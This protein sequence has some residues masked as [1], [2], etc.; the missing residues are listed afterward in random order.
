[1]KNVLQASWLRFAI[2]GSGLL[3]VNGCN[4]LSDAQLTQILTSF[5][6]TS[7]NAFVTNLIGA[8]IDSGTT[9]A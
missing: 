1:M 5:I 7:L 6:S 4:P 3:M 2:P 8:L 9:M